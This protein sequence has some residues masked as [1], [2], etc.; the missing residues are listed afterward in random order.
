M[1]TLCT[2]YKKLLLIMPQNIWSITWYTGHLLVLQLRQNKS[3]SIQVKCVTAVMI[4]VSC[5]QGRDGL[6]A[7]GELRRRM[8]R[9]HHQNL[10][11]TKKGPRSNF[12]FC[13]LQSLFPTIQKSCVPILML[14][15][16]CAAFYLI[17]CG[18][19]PS[20]RPNLTLGIT[21]FRAYTHM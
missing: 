2:I 3:E 11:S 4:L 8:L 16:K 18:N 9:G 10:T 19:K 5:S 21:S 7:L 13:V 1:K 15:S 14:V 17:Y 12:S 6:C 20:I